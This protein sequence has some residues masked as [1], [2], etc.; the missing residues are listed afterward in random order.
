MY[1][2]TTNLVPF[3]N[4]NHPGRLTMAG[5]AIPQALSLVDREAP[6]VQT[7]NEKGVPFVKQL[8][9]VVGTI[10][11][12]EGKVLTADA[13]GVVIVDAAGQKHR[14]KAV[15]NLPF[16]M[17]GFHDDE[18]LLVKE[19]QNVHAG[20]QLYDS[21]YTRNGVLSL[22]RNMQVAYLPYK[23]YN[24]EDGL[25][26]SRSAAKQLSSHHA[27][28][29][30]YTVQETSVM[31]KSLISRYFPNVYTK[32]QLDNLDEKGFAK[33][34]ASIK[35]GDPV[36]A[37]LEKREPTPEDKMLGRLHK[38]LVNP[39]RLVKEEWHNEEPGKVVDAH[40]EGKEIRF[41]L[42]C[43]KHLEVGDKLTGL[44]GNKGIV[45]LILEDHQMPYIKSTGKPVDMLLNPASVTSRV[46][47]GQLMETAAGKIA[48]KTGKPYLIHNFSKNKNVVDLKNELNALGVDDSEPMVDPISGKDIGKILTGPQYI[49]KLYK[50]SDQNWSARNTGGYDNVGQPVKGG[51]EGSKSVGYMEMLGLIG[52]N[53]RKN[54]KEISTL[55]SEDNS[56]YWAKFLTGQPLPKPKTTFATQKFLNYLTA[57]GIKTSIH[58]G[59][60][61]AT[62]LTDKDVIGMSHGVV[63]EPTM[64]SAKNLEP[65]K[66]GLFDPA[67]TGGLKGTRWTHYSLAEPIAHPLMERPI[68]SILGLNTREFDGIAHGDIGVRKEG[69]TYHLHDVVT[70]K[71]LKSVNVNKSKPV[72]EPEIAEAEP[73]DDDTEQLSL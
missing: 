11:P 71:L 65:E 3:L 50:T 6:L 9:A 23:G 54:L 60:I 41:I 2:V 1:T 39:Y 10:S 73:E 49:I 40:T 5:K 16:N 59:V 44:H 15:K 19:G 70:G 62:P 22:G 67:T 48:Q 34:G 33:Q 7:T 57:S 12:V 17:K 63:K 32:E 30:D 42:R 52:S 37:V 55:K 58:D 47:L 28:K 51:E 8:S 14:V 20:Q 46:N 26:I 68:K 36:Y 21:N 13:K 31:R 64:I 25:I 43:V 27:Y 4:S 66:G 45:S 56:E 24:H 53:A 35:N 18:S 72:D 69:N 38:T 29:I 61:R